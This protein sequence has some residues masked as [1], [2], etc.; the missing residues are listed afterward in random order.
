[1]MAGT[2]G[3]APSLLV[4]IR[5]A[6]IEQLE[7]AYFLQKVL[8]AKLKLSMQNGLMLVIGLNAEVNNG[9]L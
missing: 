5:F 7:N 8:L 9:N 4:R 1:M 2:P 6:E 3:I